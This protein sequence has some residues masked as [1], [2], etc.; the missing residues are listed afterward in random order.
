MIT[1]IGTSA[2]TSI[3]TS[4]ANHLCALPE[5]IRSDLYMVVNQ[6][7]SIAYMYEFTSVSL[8]LPLS[9]N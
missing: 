6:T 9:L 8:T 7:C 4:I 3:D 1:S 5:K 2:D